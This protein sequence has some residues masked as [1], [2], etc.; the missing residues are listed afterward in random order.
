MPICNHFHAGQ[1]NSDETRT[2]Q[3]GA[4]L[5]CPCLRGTPSSRNT[6][7]CHEKL[8]SLWQPTVKISWS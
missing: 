3:G 1:A 8:E 2:F 7:F 4:H 5:L 6:K